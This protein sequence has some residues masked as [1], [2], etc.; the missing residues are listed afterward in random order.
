VSEGREALEDALEL[1]GRRP[2]RALLGLSSLRVL[3]GN[4]DGLLDDV[5]E[6]LRAAE[7]LGDPLVLAQAWNLLGRVEGTMIGAMARADRA[8]RQALAHAERGNLRAERAESI[9]WLMMS[10]NFGPLPVDEAIALCKHFHDEAVGDPFIQ[11]NA[12]V[13]RAA[14]EAMRGDFDLARALIAEGRQTIADL[15]LSLMAATTAQEAFYIEMLA[16]NADE[17]LRIMLESYAAL[18]PMGER[19]YL[20]TA[21]A[22][23]AHAFCALD[24]LVEA[25]RFSRKSEE[26]AARDDTFSQVL[27]RSARAKT[28]ALAGDHTE[29]QELGRQ[30]VAL[31]EETDFLNTRGD[32]LADYAVV[33]ALDGRHADAATALARAAEH[34]E[35]K[36]NTTSLEQVRR[37]LARSRIST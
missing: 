7:E 19:S 24:D 1:A 27:W 10:A 34:F 5:L 31:A 18:E 20:S 13:E 22:L 4:S 11:G 6:A 3:S 26:A 32:T 37:Q 14:L 30:A 8:W 29:A 17:A 35:R 15:G 36:G 25:E 23:L 21:A 16:G 33:L 12:R 9:G 28:S 2:A